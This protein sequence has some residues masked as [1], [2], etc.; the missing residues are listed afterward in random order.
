MKWAMFCARRVHD[1]RC[2]WTEDQGQDLVRTYLRQ[3]SRVP[4][5][6]RE[7]EVAIAKRI[8][9]GE[10]RITKTMSRSLLVAHHVGVIAKEVAAGKRTLRDTVAQP[11]TELTERPRAQAEPVS[12][13]PP[14]CWRA[15]PP[16]GATSTF[17]RR[18]TP[19]CPADR[20]HGGASVGA[21]GALSRLQ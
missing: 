7:G 20:P 10:L 4:V 9:R 6:T 15:P 21:V 5:L 1:G 16:S 14:R 11:D 3:M 17:S 13:F 2:F 8:E 19:C 12:V 18:P